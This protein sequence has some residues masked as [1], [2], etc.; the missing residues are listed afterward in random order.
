[1]AVIVYFFVVK[2]VFLSSQVKTS[3]LL[4]VHN[5]LKLYKVLLF[6]FTHS[7]PSQQSIA[8][9]SGVFLRHLSICIE[10]LLTWNWPMPTAFS[11]GKWSLRVILQRFLTARCLL[12]ESCSK[13][14]RLNWSIDLANQNEGFSL[15]TNQIVIQSHSDAIFPR[16]SLGYRRSCNDITSSI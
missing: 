12:L 5:H 10:K 7:T 3:S 1:M 2:R 8:L 13:S 11:G 4:L 9:S 14:D 16:F 6:H 15:L